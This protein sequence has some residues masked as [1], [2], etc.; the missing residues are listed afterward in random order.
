LEEEEEEGDQVS[1][2]QA[3][4]EDLLDVEDFNFV[5][6]LVHFDDEDT[7]D[8]FFDLLVE[9]DFRR[10]CYTRN[11]NVLVMLFLVDEWLRL[12]KIKSGQRII[13][14]RRFMF[15]Y[16]VKTC[17]KFYVIQPGL[18]LFLNHCV[19]LS[20]LD[21]YNYRFLCAWEY[22]LFCSILCMREA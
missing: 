3:I 2:N 20:A 12:K 5:K 14:R 21:V 19:L 4:D 17:S 1:T 11:F 8:T 16:K 9:L 10:F 13:I 22:S 7:E 6:Y 18:D 15:K